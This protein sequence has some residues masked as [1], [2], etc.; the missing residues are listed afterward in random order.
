M[1]K[2]KKILI[3]LLIIGLAVACGGDNDQVGDEETTPNI[4]LSI[5]PDISILPYGAN[6]ELKWDITEATVATLNGD[7]IELNGTKIFMNLIE[8]K[9]FI[10]VATNIEKSFTLEKV[11]NID[12]APTAPLTFDLKFVNISNRYYFSTD[13][14]MEV[15]IH[16]NSIGEVI[17]KIDIVFT[18]DYDHGEPG[19]IDPVYQSKKDESYD[20]LKEAI[21]TIYYSSNLDSNDFDLAKI[22]ED[23]IDEFFTAP[24][25]LTIVPNYSD[26]IPDGS[27]IGG[28]RYYDGAYRG[29]KR[30]E[31][32]GFKNKE[33]G[34]RGLILISNKQDSAWPD[35]FFSSKAT[36]VEIIREN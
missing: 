23:K 26:Y 28:D 29:L 13:G 18:Y 3:F 36:N 12:K 20:F 27:K 32:Y 1:K 19:F 2:S 8:N 33:S 24:N 21:E 16:K 14:S 35:Y 17:K 10:I 9:S 7:E 11:V 31:V 6:V 5:S 25:V 22:S 34:K 30:G 4:E 15:P